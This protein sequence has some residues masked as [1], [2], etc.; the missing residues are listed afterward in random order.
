M[1]ET[2]FLAFPRA[3]L[4]GDGMLSRDEA[5]DLQAELRRVPEEERSSRLLPED[6]AELDTLLGEP[7]CCNCGDTVPTPVPEVPSCQK[8]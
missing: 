3:D 5:C 1:A 7:L 6:Q 8:Q 2:L 4:D